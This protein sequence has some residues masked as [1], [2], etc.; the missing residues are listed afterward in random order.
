MIDFDHK[1]LGEKSSVALKTMAASS[2]YDSQL[3]EALDRVIKNMEWIPCALSIKKLTPGMVMDEELDFSDAGETLSL[4]AT[5]T[6]QDIDRLKNR[7]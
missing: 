3:V 4:G 1:L 6:Q 5:L 2:H 7:F